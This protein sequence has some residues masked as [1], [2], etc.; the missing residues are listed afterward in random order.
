[1]KRITSSLLA[2]LLALS[3]LIG[4]VPAA[5]AA[6]AD[7]IESINSTE[8]VDSTETEDVLDESKEVAVHAAE[9]NV[10]EVGGTGYSTLE[11][12]ISAAAEGTTVTLLAD[13]TVET[14]LTISKALILDLNGNTLTVSTNGD[15][16]SVED[17]TLTL[18]NSGSTGKYVFNCSASGSDGIFVSNTTEGTVTTLNINSNVEISTTSIVNSAIHAYASNGSAV[19]NMNDGKI[20]VSGNGQFSA[21]IADQNSTVNVNGGEFDLNVD[22]ES[23]S[24]RNDVVGVLAWGQNGVQKNI[25]VNIKGGTFKVGG[26]NAFAQAVQVG[27]KNGASE[28]VT[29]NIS[30]GNVILNPTDGGKG[31][32]YAPYN[33]TYATA[34]M[35]GGSVSGNV[36]A[37]TITNKGED[38]ADLSVSDGTFTTTADAQLNV[39]KYV[40]EGSTYDSETGTVTSDSSTPGV[41]MV[42]TTTYNTLEEAISALNST[43][44]TLKLLDESAW[45]TATPV[46]WEAGEQSGYVA[47]LTDALTAAY[48]A[49]AANIKIVCRPGADVGTMTHG[50]V[51]DNITIYGNNAYISGGECELEV[52]TYKFSRE[53]GAQ[54]TTNGV[55]L[56]KDIVI[57]AYELDNLGVWGERHTTHTVNVNLT[58]CD[59]KALEKNVQRVYISGTT[60][61]NEITLKNCDFITA[62][63][64]VYSNADGQISIDT[65]SF[66]GSK[67]PVN[68][69]HKANGEQRL[70]V[71]N[72]T[73]KN[74][75][76]NGEWNQFAAPVRFVNSG[77]GTQSATVDTCTF[78]G[79]VGSNGDILI[80]DGRTGQESNNVSLTVTNTTATVQAQKPGYYD[81]TA[82]DETKG[83][84]QPVTSG[85]TL[86]TSVEEMLPTALTAYV[87]VNNGT[88]KY[89]TLDAAIA[90]AEP[91]G[92]VITYTVTGVV[93]TDATGWI[94]VAKAGL[95]ADLTEVKFVGVGTGAGI[96][97]NGGLAILADQSYDIDVS[98][99]NL[100][101]RKPN[102]QYGG[103]YGHSTNYFTCWLRNKNAAGNTVSYTNCTFPNGACNNQYGKTVYANCKFT[104]ATSGK[105]NL[106]NYGGN[107]EIK[108][109][110]FTGT[111]GIKTYNEGTLAVAPT[112]KIEGTT[113]NG[114]TEKA[115]VVASKAT[116][117]TFDNVTTMDCEKGTFEK[118]IEN[119]GET[120]TITANGSGISGSFTITAE[121]GEEAAKD[122]F[123][124]S[125][126][127]FNSEVSS[128]YCA[129]GF[130]VKANGNG[131]YGVVGSTQT[132]KGTRENPYT[133]DDLSTMTRAEYIAAQTRLG[134]TMYVTV[135]DYSYETN[136]TLGNGTADNSDRDSTKMNYYGAP[137][138]KEG[139]Y[140]DAAVGKNIV[141]VGGNITSGVT[142]YKDV[143][144]PG[145]SFL[146]AVPAYTN[147]TFEGTTF[148]NVMSFNYQLYTSPWSQLGELKFDG[149]TFNGI[150]VGA[151]A[152]QTLT[153]NNCNF[154][155]YTNTYA[156][157]GKNVGANNSNPIWVR[158]AYGNWTKGDNEGQGSDFK[159]LTTINFT[160][161]TVVST[162]PVKFERIAQWEMPTT[163]TVT[164]NSFDIRD[165][166]EK[167]NVGLYFGAN[168][169]F[170]LIAQDNTKSD[171][172]AALYTAAYKA[173]NEKDYVGLPA[174]STV[175][176]VAGEKVELDALKWKS[177]KKLTLKTTEEVASV[178]NAKGTVVNFASLSDAIAAANDGDT[179]TLLKS[180][181]GNGI[182]IETKNFATNGLT[183]D[184]GGHT[185]SV[186][187]VLV[188]STGTGT[189][190]F[191]L[192]EGG[193]V[194]F[195]NGTIAGVTKGTKPAEDTPDWH[196]A[197]AM[198]IQNYC[199]L[200]LKSMTITGGDETVYTMSNNHG[201]IVIENTTINAGSAKGYG[202][203]PFAFD[204]CGYDSYTGVSVTVKGSSTINGD[205]EVSRSSNNKNL[206]GLTLEG[207]TITGKLVI[208][209]S[210]T[211]GENTTITKSDSFEVAAPAGYK[212]DKGTL[213]KITYVAKVGMGK[214]FTS[215]QEAIN[216]AE[217][218]N[219][220]VTLLADTTEDVVIS[221]NITLDLGG[222]T[223]TNTNAGK[224]TISVTGGTV[225]VKNGNV[226]GGTSY[227][228][229]EVTKGSNANLTLEGVTATA[230]NT[231]SS[232][233]D[234]YGT[235]TI[236]SGTY[237]GGLN[238]VK[239]EEGSTLTINGGTFT[240]SYAKGWSYNGV[241]LSAGIT[242]I[243]GGNFIQNATT[244]AKSYPS[245]ILA[246]LVEGYTSKIE[247]TGGSFTNNKSDG[248]I[249][250]GYGK[251]TSDN[252]EVSGGTFNKSISVDYCADGFIP[253]KNADG[254]YGVKEGKYVAKIGSKNYETLAD[255]IRLA[256]NGK[257][258]TLLANVTENVEISKGKRVTLDLNGYTLN[259]GTGTAK[260]ALTNYGT[261]TIKDSS[262][263]KTGTIKRDDNGTV[264]ET[265]YYVI[266]NQGTMTIESGT[267]INNSGYR[268]ANSTGS[269]VGSSLICNG[270]CD[271]GG[272]L[273]IKGGTFTQNNFIAIKNGALG[274]LNVTGG[275]ITSNHSAIQNWFKADITGGEIKGQL[276]TDA[277]K[278][279]ESVGE[280]KIGG[281]AKFT[282]EIVMDITG[283]VA[284]TL[285]INGGNL[286][287]TNWRITSAAANAGA[288]P[289]VSGGT[290]SSAVKEEYCATGFIP[291][292][293][294]DGT[295]GVKAGTYVAEVNGT[296]YETLQAAIDA[297]PRKGTVKLLANTR[298]NVTIDKMMTLDLNGHTLNG[299]TEKGKPAL[300]ITARTVTIKDSSE[301]QT[302]T[303]MREDTAENSGVSSH[304]VID[305][306][307]NAWVMFESG[308]V[309]NNSG[310]DKGKGASLV[311]VGDDSVAEYPGLNIKG[312]T[313]TQDNFI[314]IKVDRGDLFLNGGTLN[315]ANSYAI[316]AWHRATI[317]GGTVNGDVAAWTYS[318]G[319]NSDI[320]I[321]GGTINGDVTSVNYG[322]AE[323]KTAKVSITGGRVT[324]ELDTR[325]Y[326]PATSELT[327]IDDATKATIGVTGGTFDKNPM[328][329]VVE[330]ST[331]K[332]NGDGTFGVEKAYLAKVG[333]TSYYTMEEAF[334]AQTASGK[335]IVLLRDYTTGSPFNSGTINRTVDLNGHTWTCTGTDA[336]S[337]AFEINNP[338][339]T[340]TVKNG[341]IVSS[342]LV[343]LIPS[344][345]GGTIKYDNSGLVFEGVEMSTTATSGIETNGNNTNDSVT[346]KNSTLNV[347]NG[348]GIYFPS[349]GT[350]TIENST[351]NAKTMG[352]QV[353]AGSLSINEGSAIT[354][355]DGPVDKTENDGAIQD[356]A[357]ISIVNRTSYKGLGTITVTGGT[358][359]AK[360]GNAAIKAYNW[361][362]NNETDFTEPTKVE[363]SGGTFSAEVPAD[364]CAP[365][366]VPQ[367]NGD[368]TYGVA[369][370]PAVAK[371]GETEFTSLKDAIATAEAGATIEIIRDIN[372]PAVSYEITKNLTINLNSNKI[373]AD[374]YDAVFQIS[375]E[376]ANVVLNGPGEV[377]AVENTGSAGKYAMAVWACGAGCTVTINGEVKFSQTIEH[378]DCKQYDMIYSSKGTIIINGGHYES[379]TP[380]WTLNCKDAAYKDGTAKI[381]VN[382]GTFVGYD[383]RNNTAE[384]KGTSFV[385][386]GVGVDNNTDGTFT[387][388]PNMVAQIVDADGNSVA[389]YATLKEAVNAAKSGETV[390]VLKEATVEER[391]TAEANITIDLN[392]KTVTVADGAGTMLKTTGDVTIK[393]G[394][395][396]SAVTANII[397]AYGKLKLESV[398]IYGSTVDGSNLVNVRGNAEVTIDAA[399]EIVADGVGVAVFVGEESAAKDA[400]YTLNIYGKVTQKGK[401]YA[402]SGNGSYPGTSYINIYEGAEVKA[403]NIAEKKDC[404]AIYQPQA[405]EINVYGGLVEGY[406]AIVMKS[407]TLNISGGTV[408][409]IRN[410]NVL[411]DNNSAG[412]GASYDG[413]AIVVDSRKTGYAGN[414]KINVTGGTVESYYSTAIREIGNDSSMTQLV[415]LTVT[416]GEIR[417]ASKNLTNAE[418]D[419]L[420]RDISVSNV[421]ISGGTFNHEVQADY[422]AV[423]YEPSEKDASGMYTVQKVSGNAYYTDD[424]G[425]L[426]YG[427]LTTLLNNEATVGRV[428]TLID[429]VDYKGSLVVEGNRTINLAGYT[430][431]SEFYVF[432]TNGCGIK[433]STDGSALIKVAPEKLVFMSNNEQ[434]PIYDS[435]NKGYRLFNCKVKGKC[436]TNGD[437][438]TIWVLPEFENKAAYKLLKSGNAHN[439]TISVTISW[440]G[441]DGPAAQE[442]T[443]KQSLIDIYAAGEG[444]AT[445]T[446]RLTG[447]GTALSGEMSNIKAQSSIKSGAGVSFT[448][449]EYSLSN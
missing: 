249:F 231:G 356:G 345:M 282:G 174:G 277:W 158:P 309:K 26:K 80:G 32:V 180:C 88:D 329:Y 55:Y 15:G 410:D 248:K 68:F 437:S 427:Y 62:A 160:G 191:Q 348:F 344:A 243:S 317:K 211:L 287:V 352:V 364:L 20:A 17:T 444:G 58:D 418:N 162:R 125:A 316:E 392:Q 378:E 365:G 342:Q 319:S 291:T 340:L 423:G 166:G 169:K 376:N 347:P 260:A 46:Y 234:N 337:A 396:T 78:A 89:E 179:V 259:G 391:I 293:N 38:T 280:T 225:T 131:T 374:G 213:T 335:P 13:T 448:G 400:K 22:F 447:L 33:S 48:K 30:G 405:G 52:D 311:R 339:V 354:V 434:L 375:G 118:D 104:N 310:N 91:V 106:W 69:N 313:F 195:Q 232:M 161:N 240:L 382:G 358:F 25:A 230:G 1:M 73:F 359:T 303:I 346:L 336:N 94:Q 5:Y 301:A 184:F 254:T 299:G 143:D 57:N 322:N 113:F 325:S 145:T 292:Q 200:T 188:G 116:D 206:V 239:S 187:G 370:A 247:I 189:N 315:C 178:T 59:G 421:A 393:N 295:Y 39:E 397:N 34:T 429:S 258:I 381:I 218:D 56:D 221:K 433:D 107:T 35:T 49:N 425:N 95:T 117:I 443:F 83:A 203:G 137:G 432:V 6:P 81:G 18:T 332:E 66:T 449:K 154:G 122:E 108:N 97:I 237:T 323:G 439:A 349:S 394:T 380:A 298:E 283:S 415:E 111:R 377:V 54:D 14:T 42:G 220:T 92:G 115:A 387:A 276:W 186:G 357:A 93:S 157:N 441:N 284:P 333:E 372:T 330:G 197:P 75:G 250:Y 424:D 435:A 144:N 183:V 43:D 368:G 65:C 171:N 288:K 217:G 146:L 255:A 408:R 8:T 44:Y 139:Q 28:N 338:N 132:T 196:G 175:T 227:Y 101:L 275:T 362:N 395:L 29:V 82:T 198:V 414:V 326:N 212:W 60:G 367:D 416:G 190:A 305:I 350:L 21:V 51:A 120:T 135:G 252:F 438:A 361:A 308:N 226:V 102:P 176:N 312:G 110:T 149:C 264:G 224:A 37:L 153:F 426:H 411:G 302:G 442:F 155:N 150:I 70:T 261:I 7:T 409:G 172:T 278:E 53:T 268:Q 271:E 209:S 205:I 11:A 16:I 177:D 204:V 136:G 2:L 384:G 84:K 355:S 228:N 173:P 159:S 321:S 272:T 286:N 168:A 366:Y 402:I 142:G 202:Y 241:I 314:V 130:E 98:F 3:M 128:D 99:E 360:T 318:G 257:T 36:T 40:A 265:S 285:A 74:C 201:D 267:V 236:T 210:I 147:V 296:K 181:N 327:S 129:D 297:A 273:T 371:I 222:K 351:I 407:G 436:E 86:N 164:G 63:T 124:I 343:G 121:K 334:K 419:I 246:M 163:V 182:K 279:S 269:M 76:D 369:K 445:F 45:N 119:S 446:L 281:D 300:T 72:S 134:G 194:T 96:T 412:N 156:E 401:S 242:N 71:S 440:T 148:K 238:V 388:K 353:C 12:A 245:V 331:V 262:A 428:I 152:A 328:K 306:Q 386:A 207:G 167:K 304:Y 114:L 77:S 229:I 109:S 289:A 216:Y 79:T 251:A 270:D 399:S 403:N 244:P 290:F 324:G 398:K 100:T 256:A 420:V 138:A 422:C 266:R 383:P 235:L 170:N 253:T 140:S 67:V 61:K 123:N 151:I 320:T 390:I 430:F 341:K 373:T 192:L 165:T 406:C 294:A 19:V 87:T 85:E 413:S 24:D 141:F 219:D 417:G 9:G 223:L 90:V 215:L 127:T 23:Y 193:K 105:Y 133:L 214:E 50:H 274:V 233:I 431:E 185:Y 47:K 263:A 10:A 199:D 4:M 208:D 126:G 27:M 389:A 103:D 385:A 112:V 31:Y 379:F 307:G 363:V 64:A 41:A 404:C